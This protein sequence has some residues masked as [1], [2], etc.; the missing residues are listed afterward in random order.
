[1]SAS[2]SLGQ[3]LREAAGLGVGGEGPGLHGGRRAGWAWQPRPSW[4]AEGTVWRLPSTQGSAWQ[5]VLRQE[6]PQCKSAWGVGGQVHRPRSTLEGPRQSPSSQA[7]GPEG[8]IVVSGRRALGRHVDVP[9][10]DGA[11]RGLVPEQQARLRVR[12]GPA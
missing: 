4:R 1:M 2:S 11:A 10:R 7:W 5:S 3:G 8:T 6:G 9:E 12:R